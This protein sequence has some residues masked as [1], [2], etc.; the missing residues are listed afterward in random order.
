[1]GG[2]VVIALVAF[3]VWWI[4][5]SRNKRMAAQGG[6]N[7]GANGYSANGGIVDEKAGNLNGNGIGEAGVPNT[8]S[9]PL[10][11]TPF[12]YAHPPPEQARTDSFVSSDKVYVRFFRIVPFHLSSTF[13]KT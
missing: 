2:V 9:A 12:L 1:M 3:A 5:R 4:V 11:T 10:N 13:S 7:A 8:T 6:Y